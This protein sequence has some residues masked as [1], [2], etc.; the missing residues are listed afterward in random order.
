MFRA[1]ELVIEGNVHKW[2]NIDGE[3]EN[4]GKELHFVN[5]PGSVKICARK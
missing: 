3:G 4:L 2:V 5:H 1:K